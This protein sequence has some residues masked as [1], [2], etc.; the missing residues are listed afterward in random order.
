M[1]SRRNLIVSMLLV[2]ILVGASAWIQIERDRRF[3]SDDPAGQVLYVQSPAVMK[4]L[5]LSYQG[6]AADLYWIRAIQYFGGSRREELHRN[7]Y[8]LL[9]PLLNISTTL[10]PRFNVAYRFGAIFLAEAPPGGPGRPDLAIAL[11]QKGIAAMPERWLYYQDLGYVHYWARHDFKTAAEW[12]R[13]GSEVPGAPW[14]L[15]SLAANTLAQGGHRQT[16]RLLYQAL[17]KTADNDFLR[18]DALR[19]LEQ[20]DAM[21]LREALQNAVD[22][23]KNEGGKPPYTWAGLVAAGVLR[24]VPVDPAGTEY[25]LGPYAGHVDVHQKSPLQPLPDEPHATGGPAR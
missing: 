8:E 18:N 17:A 16:S 22:R 1:P 10:D 2:V 15:K 19:R 23:Y 9:Y 14:W 24:G 5:T 3:G 13:K 4:R 12:F 11:L 25:I 21:D 7:N 6:L 20:L